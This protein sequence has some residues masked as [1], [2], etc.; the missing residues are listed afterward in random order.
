MSEGRAGDEIDEDDDDDRAPKLT[1][2][3]A[4][5]RVARRDS[6]FM[7]RLSALRSDVNSGH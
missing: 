3:E 7:Q 2:E 6:A 5:A 4:F 1:L